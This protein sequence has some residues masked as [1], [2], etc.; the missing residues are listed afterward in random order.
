M[1]NVGKLTDFALGFASEDSSAPAALFSW[2]EPKIHRMQASS[3]EKN[4]QLKP[5]VF[6]G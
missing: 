4:A 1:S 2:C 6:W 3:V 5:G